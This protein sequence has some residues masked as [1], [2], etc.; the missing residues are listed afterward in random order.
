MITP[1]QLHHVVGH[2]RPEHM[3]SGLIVPLFYFEIAGRAA[4]RAN[5]TT[6]AQQCDFAW[7]L[8]APDNGPETFLFFNTIRRA[9]R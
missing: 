1:S 7:Q 5:L 8:A 4:A 3:I 9:Q 6:F 2:D